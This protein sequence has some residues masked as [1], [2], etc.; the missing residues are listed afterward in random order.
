MD[1]H[2]VYKFDFTG[3][4]QKDYATCLY[5]EVYCAEEMRAKALTFVPTDESVFTYRKG[6]GFTEESHAQLIDRGEPD[7][8]RRDFVQGSEEAEFIIEVPR[9]QYELMVISG[10]AKKESVTILEGVNGRKAGGDLIPAGRY[11][12]KLIPIIQEED[13]PVRLKISTEP[14]YSWKVNYIIMNVVKGY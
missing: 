9:G 1:N 4:T 12:C 14:G 8:L 10:D 6:Y 2:T 7:V 13:E 5:D 3:D 11:Q